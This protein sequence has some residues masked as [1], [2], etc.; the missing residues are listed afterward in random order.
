VPGIEK[1]LF[2]AICP[3]DSVMFRSAVMVDYL[4]SLAVWFKEGHALV[5]LTKDVKLKN[6]DWQRRGI[7]RRF[8]Q[9]SFDRAVQIRA[10]MQNVG[11]MEMNLAACW[12]VLLDVTHDLAEELKEM[13]Q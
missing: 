11:F 3:V 1:V 5:W 13:L 2:E 8:P 10:W 6:L 7:T 12:N 9:A 4:P